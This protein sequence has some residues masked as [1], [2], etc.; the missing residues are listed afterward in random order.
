MVSRASE[1]SPIVDHA[2]GLPGHD[3]LGSLFHFLGV[4]NFVE[5]YQNYSKLF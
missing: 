4:S 1:I 2:K 3:C 5:I